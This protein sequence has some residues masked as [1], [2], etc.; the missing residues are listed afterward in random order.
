MSELRKLFGV[1]QAIVALALGIFCLSPSGCTSVSGKIDEAAPA[2]DGKKDDASPSVIK[3][4]QSPVDVGFLLSMTFDE[5][6]KISPANAHVLPNYNVAADSITVSSKA[7]DG[8]PRRATA[9]GHVFMQI[10]FPDALVA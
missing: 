9:K 4:D 1:R 2:K 7:D 5:A 3:A 6:Q 8:Q 10:D